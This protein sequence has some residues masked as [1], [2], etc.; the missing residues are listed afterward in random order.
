MPITPPRLDDL[1]F[2]RTVEELL[3]RIPVH[4]PEWTDHNPGDPGVALIHLFAYLAEQV[5]YRLNRVP[6]KNHVELLKLLG[7]RLRPARAARPRLPLLLPPPRPLPG[8]P[9][10]AGAGARARAGPPPPIFET[11]VA[12]DVVPAQP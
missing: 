4:A 7:V 10:A 3:R 1:G 9:R 5:G 11:D 2:D 8:S 6:E 12:V